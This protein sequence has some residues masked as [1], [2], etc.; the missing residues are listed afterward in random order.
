MAV[1]SSQIP[2]KTVEQIFD[3]RYPL[4]KWKDSNYS[5]LDKFSMRGRKGFVTGAAGGL[6][7]NAAAALAQAGA[8]VALVDLPSQEDKLTELAKDMSER[9]GTNVIALTCDVTDTV[10]VAELKTQ[11]VEQLGTVDFAFLN[12][13][14]NVPGDDQDATEEVWTRTININLNGTYRTGRIA[15][16]IM[17]EHGH[18]GSLIFTASLSGHNANYMMGSPTPVNAYGATKAAIME[19]SRYLAAALAKTASVPT[20][21]PPDTCG[22]EFSMAVSTC[23]ATTLCSKSCQCTVSARMTRL[24]AR[25]SS[26]PATP[27]RTLLALTFA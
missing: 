13:G 19:H 21:S 18:G 26:S 22:L 24:P 16:E 9:F 5:I 8:D 27:P 3:E 25:Y 11:L 7:R 20:P 1:E 6:G 17:R 15:H 10:Q 2:E 12:A 4:D 23:L 14:V